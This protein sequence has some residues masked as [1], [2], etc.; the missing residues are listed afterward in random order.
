MVSMC[1]GMVGITLKKN[2]KGY[3]NDKI[4]MAR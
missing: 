2:N 4:N 1:S 3:L